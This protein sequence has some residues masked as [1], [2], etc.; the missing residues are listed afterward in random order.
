MANLDRYIFKT[1]SKMI[2]FLKIHG[3]KTPFSR[4]VNVL[5]EFGEDDENEPYIV[6]CLIDKINNTWTRK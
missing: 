3:F 2:S 4:I 1:E 6:N 5:F